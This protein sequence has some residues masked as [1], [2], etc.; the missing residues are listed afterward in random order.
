MYHVV[1]MQVYGK[2]HKLSQRRF[3][4]FT[5]SFEYSAT[6]HNNSL[7]NPD[8][9]AANRQ[10]MLQGA[11]RGSSITIALRDMPPRYYFVADGTS[12]TPL[13]HVPLKRACYVSLFKNANMSNTIRLA[14]LCWHTAPSG[15]AQ[16][17]I[18]LSDHH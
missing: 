4:S 15:F 13:S 18:Q 7:L 10:F 12:I 2:T 17:Q 11:N 9:S 6:G 5:V 3:P 14:Q 8:F 16:L 1:I